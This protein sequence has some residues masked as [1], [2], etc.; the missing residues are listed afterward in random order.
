M[1]VR[2]CFL[3]QLSQDNCS[4]KQLKTFTSVREAID[5]TVDAKDK[6]DESSS[7][8]HFVMSSLD[9]QS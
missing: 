8:N 7:T 1:S 6:L 5:S 2:H 9:G 3:E 4:G